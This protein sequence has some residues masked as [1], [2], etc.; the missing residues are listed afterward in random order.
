MIRIVSERLL[1]VTGSSEVHWMEQGRVFRYY[2]CMEC[3]NIMDCTKSS[4]IKVNGA[5]NS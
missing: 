2:R 4:G 3:C 5:G 1:S